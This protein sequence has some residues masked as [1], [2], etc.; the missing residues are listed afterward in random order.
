MKD[1]TLEIGNWKSILDAQC[2]EHCLMQVRGVHHADANFMSGTV[3]VHYDEAQVAIA[4]LEQMLD[5]GGFECA[6]EI[7]PKHIVKPSDPPA[8]VA[9]MDHSMH[10][11]HAMPMPAAPAKKDEHAGHEAMSGEMAGM[12][13]EMGHS[14]SMS[15]DAMVND[16]RNRFLVALVFAVPIFLYS[17]LFTDFFKI[18]L[19]V[20]FGLTPKCFRSF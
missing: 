10:A 1:T 13:H 2:I 3:T 16:M 15:M 14:G 18:V 4:D 9:T 19:P 17:P 11:G 7:T 6:G 20:P 12:A 8:A 5:H